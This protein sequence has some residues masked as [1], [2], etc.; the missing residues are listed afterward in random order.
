MSAIINN[1]GFPGALFGAGLGYVFGGPDLLSLGIGAGAGYLAYPYV[2]NTVIG[3]LPSF[4]QREYV[5]PAA[6]GGVIGYQ[7]YFGDLMYAGAGAVAGAGLEYLI[8]KY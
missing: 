3:A 6:L 4:E 8:N 2:Q 1:T 5:L 7:F